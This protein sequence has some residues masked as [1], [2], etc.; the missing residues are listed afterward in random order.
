ML[1]SRL[2]AGMPCVQ[3]QCGV[4]PQG[5]S[6]ASQQGAAGEERCGEFL[7][8]E[9]VKYS[10]ELTNS[11]DSSAGTS[12]PAALSVD[13]YSIGCTPSP[14]DAM[15]PACV[16][17]TVMSA[18][19]GGPAYVKVEDAAAAHHRY[20]SNLHPPHEPN[21]AFTSAG[22]GYLPHAA[23]AS[24]F[25]TAGGHSWDECSPRHDYFAA[26]QR[27]HAVSRLSL[28]SLK[29]TQ[30][31]GNQ[32]FSACQMKFDGS[33]HVSMNLDVVGTR[34]LSLEP[35]GSGG[36]L[37]VA[38]AHEKA[39]AGDTGFL[40]PLQLP[41]AHGYGSDQQQHHYAEHRGVPSSW[42]AS[43]PGRGG[44]PGAEGLCAVCGDNAACQHYGVRT[45]E[46]C[47][48]FFKR[49]VQK[50]A[51]YVCLAARSCP[52]DKRRRNRCQYC[53]FQKCLV[54]GMVKEVV[55]TDGLKGR[56]G[57]LP[58]KPKATHDWS[59]KPAISMLSALVRAHMD[60]NPIASRLDY[61]KFQAN[62]GSPGEDEA[63]H[64][65][66]FYDR[67]TGS[68]DIIRS[69]A[70]KIP[71]FASLPKHD[72]DLLFHSAFL[73]LFVLRLAYRSNPEEGKLVFCD[74]SVWHRLQCR[75]G[76][77]EWLD[78]IVE[79]SANLQRMD[80]D[81]ATFSCISALALITER[82]GLKE[83]GRVKELQNTVVK[84]LKN[85]L[86]YVA[87][88]GQCGPSHVSGLLETLPLLRTLCTCGLQRIFYLKL[89]DL[90]PPPATVDQLFL[91][92]L[93]F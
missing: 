66:H 17:G 79:F 57:R 33:F 92:T 7:T 70:H 16:F 90:V 52:V 62:P 59:T 71:G 6:P 49:T 53:R 80:L 89:E 43:T 72:Q 12:G 44:L 82:R 9:F 75:R 3:T 41:H 5:A 21:Q 10:M 78:G 13:G 4:S 93:P 28:F 30:H 85:S 67:L 76:F 45:C 11:E 1:D 18:Q 32:S 47:K 19:G 35:G 39:R 54:V 37:S 60:S 81:I 48:G 84:C 22:S 55:R 68:M 56:R 86:S 36:I 24:N 46:G 63:E 58:S 26:V 29:H 88:G 38:D 87:D 64:V 40:H 83:Q 74:G 50:N 51:K 65:R 25:H 61:S 2:P 20:Q 34:Q 31:H 69:W 77:G 23:L 42:C 14:Y 15:K 8:P 73:E 27:K 91:D